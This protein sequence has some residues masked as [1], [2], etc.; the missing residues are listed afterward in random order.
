[1]RRRGDRPVNPR[2]GAAARIPL[3]AFRPEARR[4]R[5]LPSLAARSALRLD[6]H[7]TAAILPQLSDLG[8]FHDLRAGVHVTQRVPCICACFRGLSLA[9]AL[10]AALGLPARARGQIPNPLDLPIFRPALAEGKPIVVSAAEAQGWTEDN[11]HVLLLKGNVVVEQGLT[12]VRMNQAILWI[13][14]GGDQPGQIVPAQI[15]A[16]GAVTLE[17]D[18][19]REQA[20][21]LFLEWRTSGGLRL[22][23]QQKLGQASAEDPF[24][25]RALDERAR[26]LN[27]PPAAAAE[28]PEAGMAERFMKGLQT[29]VQMLRQGFSAAAPPGPGAAAPPARDPFGLPG[30]GQMLRGKR[31]SI[32]P[33]NSSLFQTQT[34]DTDPGERAVAVSGGV[35]LYV[36]DPASGAFIDIS[37]DR[38][39]IWIKDLGAADSLAELRG[40]GISREQIEVYLEGHVEIRQATARGPQRGMSVLL[41]A[42]S[43]YYDVARNVALLTQSEIIIRQP[44]VP[45]PIRMQ[46]MEIRQV[47]LN[48]FEASEALFLAS[49]LP[50]DPDL[51]V[52]TRD[53]AIEA[54]QAQR[55]GLL[56]ALGAAPLGPPETRYIATATNIRPEL[57]GVPFLYIPRAEGDVEEPLGP[58]RAVRLRSDRI[59][60]TGFQI[61][62]DVFSIL[63]ARRPDNSRWLLDTDY[64]SRRGPALGTEFESTGVGLFGFAGRYNTLARGYLIYDQAP[65]DILATQ[66][67]FQRDDGLRGRFLFRHYQELDS[68][69]TF[70]G[71]YSY[72]SGRNFLEQ[73]FKPEFDNGPDQETFLQLDY[74][75]GNFG[76]QLNAQPNVRDWVNETQML[77]EGK[78][79]LI[80]YDFFNL[81]SYNAR[82][83]AGYYDFHRTND[84]LQGFGSAPFDFNR[85]APLPPSSDVPNYDDVQLGRFYLW[86]ELELPL[87]L[88]PFQIVPYGRLDLAWYTDTFDDGGGG[89]IA[90]GGGVR[91]SLPLTRIDA[92]LYS[93]LLNVSG[94]AHKVSLEFDYR[95]IAS[96]RD[97]RTLP[98][99]DRVDDAATDQ[100]RRDLRLFRLTPAG[101]AFLGNPARQIN[102]ATNPFF[103][104]TLYILRRG[105]D[106]YEEIIDSMQFLRFGMRNRWQTKRGLPGQEHTVDWMTLSAFATWFPDGARDNYG[107]SFGLVDYDYTWR[108]GDRTTFLSQGLVEP[109]SGGTRYFSA[110]WF[111]ERPE[112]LAFFLGFRF[113]DPIGT[114]ALIASSSY[115]FSEKYQLSWASSYDFGQGQN[116]GNSLV[117]TRVGTDLQVSLGLS[118]DALTNNFGV[119]FE[120]QSV[121]MPPRSTRYGGLIAGSGRESS[122]VQTAMNP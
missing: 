6:A 71:Q 52:F 42:D 102:L 2:A 82:A 85:Y 79:F 31:I 97:F 114:R 118:Y 112:R 64:L 75:T 11:F 5:A 40:R 41:L 10:A 39:V 43:G 65:T 80:G 84:N 28:G 103:D 4:S 56:G 17:K 15:Y 87:P 78:G 9:L 50:S 88:G 93:Q 63:G 55:R 57:M 3:A 119:I 91:G 60:G 96:S 74:K 66:R 73:F 58:L 120:I 48:R 106:G 21:K 98:L 86:Q 110:G 24:F 16:E 101:L 59:L 104:P 69:W 99:L 121:L 72:L 32:S 45:V 20:D 92:D 25:R 46:A 7:P 27:N 54:T 53:V 51:E 117:V 34:F 70:R 1:V 44:G 122:Y 89:R 47:N 37:T 100:A 33:R 13:G 108:L 83:A 26:F 115:A 19:K 22:T 95:N 76:A 94:L 113:I 49:K 61:G 81:F 67:I 35:T 14:Q 109:F 77:P 90:G 116:L 38:A 30:D 29:S 18:G 8:R 111:V 12:R 36:D 62:W 105:I 107:N 23:S 68:N